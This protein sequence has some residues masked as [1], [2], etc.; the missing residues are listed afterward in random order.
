MNEGMSYEK[1]QEIKNKYGFMSSWAIW[2]ELLPNEKPKTGM[3]DIS[4]F[5]DPSPELL[6][7][8]RDQNRLFHRK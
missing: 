4:F 7:M 6:K 2:R 1:F 3:G 5:I 8:L